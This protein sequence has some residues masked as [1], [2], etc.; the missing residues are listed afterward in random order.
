MFEKDLLELVKS[1]KFR[2]RNDKF[3]NKMKNDI[4]KIKSSLN[5]F[6]PA[7]KTTNMYELTPKK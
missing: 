7:D 5:V 6:I 2:N 3:Q 4:N 1:V